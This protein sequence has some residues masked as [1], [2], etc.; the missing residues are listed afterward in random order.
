MR[1]RL[2]ALLLLLA[3]C[4]PEFTQPLSPAAG[5]KVDAAL[6]GKWVEAKPDGTPMRLEVKAL[7]G[8]VM[9]VRLAKKKE[10]DALGFEG[11]VT[12]LGAMKVL[13]LKA[14]EGDLSGESLLVVRYELAADGTLSAWVMRDN[15]FRVAVKDGSLKGHESS[16]SPSSVIVT[17]TPENV[18]A[19]MQKQK[20]ESLWEPL[21]TFRKE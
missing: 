9:S 5:A 10:K 8:G 3:G 14:V 12:A 17:D 13:N 16:G 1:G 21:T 4:P 6:L 7:Q 20:S 2:A 15:A 11:H 19:F 18:R